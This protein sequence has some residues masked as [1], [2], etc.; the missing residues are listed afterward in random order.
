MIVAA[1]SRDIPAV[2]E[3][4]EEYQRGLDVSLCFQDFAAEVALL[5][6]SYVP[7]A[8]G[9]WLAREPEGLAGC[10]ALRPLGAGAAELKRLYVRGAFRGRGL[11]RALA[12]H[13]IAHARA[14]GHRELKLDTLPAM[15]QAQALYA[16][17]G[18][19]DIAPYNDNPVGGVRFMALDLAVTSP[20]S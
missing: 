20:G 1:D 4:F 2:R 12:R 3:L 13:A 9:L 16:R 15:A 5:P 11:G 19:R 18:F 17:L 7:P 10:V 8:G 6:G 14:A